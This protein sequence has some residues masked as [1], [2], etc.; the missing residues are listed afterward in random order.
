MFSATQAGVFVDGVYDYEYMEQLGDGNN[1]EE[2]FGG[3]DD[4]GNDEIVNMVNDYFSDYEP[5][6]EGTAGDDDI[7][8]MNQDAK[9]TSMELH[10]AASML[11]GASTRMTHAMK[12]VPNSGAPGQRCNPQALTPQPPPEKGS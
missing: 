5:V 2:F 6:I 8:G 10:V 11:E 3:S 4:Y 1:L 9:V 12:G 7:D